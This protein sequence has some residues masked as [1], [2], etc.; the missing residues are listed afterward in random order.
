MN[1]EQINLV[2]STFNDVRP[3]AVPAAELFLQPPLHAGPFAARALQRRP[4]P[5]A[6][7]VTK[8]VITPMLDPKVRL[9]S[10][11]WVGTAPASMCFLVL[12]F[13]DGTSKHIGVGAVQPGFDTQ[14]IFA[15][16]TNTVSSKPVEADQNCTVG[17]DGGSKTFTVY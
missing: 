5:P 17:A 1:S 9:I 15:P 10:T 12:N 4:P 13:G 8:P 6:P 16:G 2:R 3:I 7:L 14:H 11:K